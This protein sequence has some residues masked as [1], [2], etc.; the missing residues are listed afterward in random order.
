MISWF[1]NDNVNYCNLTKIPG[2]VIR[3]GHHQYNNNL[4]L[5]YYEDF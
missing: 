2:L 3:L 1:N 5:K 4:K